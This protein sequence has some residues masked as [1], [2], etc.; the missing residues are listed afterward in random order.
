MCD[1]ARIMSRFNTDPTLFNKCM[2]DAMIGF[3]SQAKK[4]IANLEAV[5]LLQSASVYTERRRQ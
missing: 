3:Y 1:S 4:L 2:Y 5:S